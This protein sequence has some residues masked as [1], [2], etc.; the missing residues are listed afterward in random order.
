MGSS[1]CSDC[2]TLT[3]FSKVVP[4]SLVDLVNKK[5]ANIRETLT[6]MCGPEE[7]SKSYGGISPYAREV[8]RDLGK[9]NLPSDVCSPGQ[10]YSF[11]PIRNV[12]TCIDCPPGFISPVVSKECT[13]CPRSTYSNKTEC[14]PCPKGYESEAMSSF[15]TKISSTPDK[16]VLIIPLLV[17]CFVF[18]LIL[19][20]LSFY[21]HRYFVHKNSL[22]FAPKLGTPCLMIFTD[23]E[24]STLL[25][26]LCNKGMEKAV[27]LHH[28]LARNLLKIYKG[29]EVKTEGDSFFVVFQDFNNG[30]RWC[31]EFQKRLMEL[32]WPSDVLQQTNLKFKVGFNGPRV[33]MGGSIGIPK[34]VKD[35]TT[36]RYDYYGPSVNLASRI[37]ALSNGGQ[38]IF[39]S[40]VS[41]ILT[42][43]DDWEYIPLGEVPIRGFNDT[44][45]IVQV[46]PNGLKE[47]KFEMNF[48][49]GAELDLNVTIASNMPHHEY[50]K[51][52]KSSRELHRI[53]SMY[54]SIPIWLKVNS[55]MI[56]QDPTLKLINRK[57]SSLG[58]KSDASAYHISPVNIL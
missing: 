13:P 8:I 30:I 7:C 42:L 25:W 55:S 34:I 31:C 37:S 49:P 4:Q 43:C 14:V 56:Q 50:V 5:L 1:W 19:V 11:D 28:S 27:H 54:D 39:E 57:G 38:I 6:L 44:V 47:R 35:S 9:F 12:L 21:L 46:V 53:W 48:R 22:R 40:Q 18:V 45:T 15:C 20:I 3:E 23:I 51:L 16:I 36:N 32:E 52:C 29:Y 33:R 26:N 58:S 24:D 2:F 41:N 17:S 10:N